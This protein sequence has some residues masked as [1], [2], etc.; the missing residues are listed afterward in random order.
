MHAGGLDVRS[1]FSDEL[2][3]GCGSGLP[4][5]DAFVLELMESGIPDAGNKVIL[6]NLPIR[7]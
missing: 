2:D 3:R 5:A 6:S 1:C 7:T 4:M